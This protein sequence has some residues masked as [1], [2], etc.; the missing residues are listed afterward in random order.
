MAMRGMPIS[1]FMPARVVISSRVCFVL[2]KI[3]PF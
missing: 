3:E 1:F 2:R